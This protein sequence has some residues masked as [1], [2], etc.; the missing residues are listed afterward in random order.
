MR[1]IGV[2]KNVLI[3]GYSIALK[4]NNAK[5]FAGAGLSIPSGYPSWEELMSPIIEQLGLKIAD[6][7][8]YYEIIEQ[9]IQ[10]FG[11]RTPI[12]DHLVQQ[13]RVKKDFNDYHR[14][15]TRLPIGS[16]WTSNY[17][18]LIERAYRKVGKN[19]NTIVCDD[20]FS[21]SKHESFKIYKIHGCVYK[22]P[23]D[24]VVSR[25]DLESYDKKYYQMNLSF[26]SAL[27]ENTFLFLG[28]GFN[29]VNFQNILGRINNTFGQNQRQHYAIMLVSGSL[30]KSKKR[31]IQ[32]KVKDLS[33][34]GIKV[35]VVRQEIEIVRILRKIE[36]A[37]IRNNV[38]ISGS[39]KNRTFKGLDLKDQEL[40]EILVKKEEDWEKLTNEF[41]FKENKPLH[42]YLSRIG[43]YLAQENFNIYSGNGF[44]T[45]EVITE[46]GS[47]YFANQDYYSDVF[48]RLKIFPL[49]HRYDPLEKQNRY[50][51]EG[52][53]GPCGV[54]IIVGGAINNSESISGTYD[55]YLLAKGMSRLIF[56]KQQNQLLKFRK[57]AEKKN[58][59][60]K[61]YEEINIAQ[62]L[63]LKEKDEELF[64][65]HFF[66]VREMWKLTI[67]TI[68][69]LVRNLSEFENLFKSI[70]IGEFLIKIKEFVK[71]RQEDFFQYVQTQSNE[72]Y[73]E[74]KSKR[75][76]LFHGKDIK[77]ATLN[78][79]IK[80]CLKKVIK[81]SSNKNVKKAERIASSL[82]MAIKKEKNYLKLFNRLF[83]IE[84]V[85]LKNQPISSY[86]ICELETLFSSKSDLFE[87]N[88]EE[89][90][91]RLN[92]Q[93]SV[94][95][96][97]RKA[98]IDSNKFEYEDEE[99]KLIS[100]HPL[101]YDENDIWKILDKFKL[102]LKHFELMKAK[103]KCYQE[104]TNEIKLKN[105]KSEKI[106]K[107][108]KNIR[109][110]DLTVNTES[111]PY[112]EGTLILPLTGISGM[113]WR[114]WKEERNRFLYHFASQKRFSKTVTFQK[115]KY[116]LSEVLIMAYDE[117][118]FKPKD[119]KD[120]SEHAFLS[121]RFII[122]CFSD[123][124][125]TKELKRISIK[126]LNWYK[127]KV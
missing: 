100:K 46:G 3:N 97:K 29:D 41:P 42:I 85:I 120:K 55:E 44:G 54:Q 61:I 15:L 73:I 63:I 99:H 119:F 10:V 65:H 36:R 58:F 104:I 60:E 86:K 87:F 27:A 53:I 11:Q 106:E 30:S 115:E 122:N 74:N 105:F 126:Y 91:H 37:V 14:Y 124:K 98:L 47:K 76:N 70:K 31:Q 68:D 4:S 22:R 64:F 95:H 78:K 89:D 112:R 121:L 25:K 21:L 20:D 19:V 6:I 26:E 23:L 8:N 56:K 107:S 51:R 66:L 52:M 48:K 72:L 67:W 114:I 90:F 110:I 39:L 75:K 96:I 9:A 1:N 18:N 109:Q 113:A 103:I 93:W 77:E 79:F 123:Y 40:K 50:Y 62:K 101:W 125:S 45:C 94:S 71:S 16:I 116:L 57:L 34:Y 81:S 88:I 111:Y 35:C 38:F 82:K 84:K 80:E 5:M 7:H 17:D 92:A 43:Q 49:P 83:E 127:H 102:H 69:Y 117:L 118:K 59:K 12:I 13:L 33:H 24:I 108:M 28:F 32:Y 2:H